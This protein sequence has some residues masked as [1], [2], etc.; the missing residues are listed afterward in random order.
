[1]NQELPK[2]APFS[3]RFEVMNEMVIAYICD[4]KCNC[5]DS[6]ICRYNK[7]HL[8][9]F[10]AHTIEES[11]ARYGKCEGNP[12]WYPE[13]FFYCVDCDRYWEKERL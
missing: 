9:D 6:E 8:F 1:M 10:C 11:H 7:N 3:F 12:E 4:G 13:R 2:T 5:N